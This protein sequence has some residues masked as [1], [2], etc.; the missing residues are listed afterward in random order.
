MEDLLC[1]KCGSKHL[2][3]HKQGFTLTTGIIGMNNIKITCLVC[4]KTFNPGEAVYNMDHY[5]ENKKIENNRNLYL[6]ITF[7]ACLIISFFSNGF[8]LLLF[9]NIIGVLFYEAFNKKK[10]KNKYK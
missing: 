10:L 2:T 7:I 9:I 8:I 5:N 1:P 4:N 3:N 6:F